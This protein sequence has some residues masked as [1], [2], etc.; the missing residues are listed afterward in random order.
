MENTIKI[1]PKLKADTIELGLLNSQTL[2]LLNN[3]LVP[4]FIILPNTNETELFRLEKAERA[5]LDNN[6]DLISDFLINHFKSDKLNVATIGNVVSQMHMHVVGRRTS[7]PY[8]P[9][10]VWGQP[11]KQS[12]QKSDIL[13][14]KQLLA[15]EFQNG[16]S[17]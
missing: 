17:S 15:S 2:L 10:V 9:D 6:I 4:W 16:F 12:Y 13:K 5:L 1:N 8:W 11:E 7:D 3:S 14:I